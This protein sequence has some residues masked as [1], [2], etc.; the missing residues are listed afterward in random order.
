MK[1]RERISLRQPRTEHA[2]HLL[3][4]GAEPSCSRS[5]RQ[6]AVGHS[7]DEMGSAGSGRETHAALAGP[8]LGTP[9]RMS[10]PRGEKWREAERYEEKRRR[11]GRRGGGWRWKWRWGGCGG[12]HGEPH[13]GPHCHPTHG[14][15]TD[16]T[17]PLQKHSWSVASKPSMMLHTTCLLCRTGEPPSCAPVLG[18][19]FGKCK[20]TERSRGLPG[21]HR[22]G[23]RPHCPTHMFART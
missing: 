15:L 22:A 21:C 20:K 2:G 6:R 9:T 13:E 4:E 12:G 18:D 7:W 14:L 8:A 1:A 16:P 5:E 17:S 11:K 10:L 3:S 23:H 19:W